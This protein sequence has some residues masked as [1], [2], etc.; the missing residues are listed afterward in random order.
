MR[1]KNVW[2]WLIISALWK[3]DL[4]TDSRCSTDFDR[5]EFDLFEL[6][7]D[8][9]WQITTYLDKLRRTLTNYYYHT[10]TTPLP[11]NYH[12]TT[13]LLPHQYHTNITPLPYHYHTLTTPIP[14]QYY[15]VTTPIINRYHTV[16][17]PLLHHYHI[18]TTPIPHQYYTVTTP[19]PHFEN[20]SQKVDGK[21]YILELGRPYKPGCIFL[22]VLVF[23]LPHAKFGS[24][25]YREDAPNFTI[26]IP[27]CNLHSKHIFVLHGHNVIIT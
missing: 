7:N 20:D 23:I 4:W 14:Y 16:T 1:L 17:T 9:P 3:S 24:N 25:D 5:S 27:T 19:L 6:S 10:I 22:I 21:F 8:I 2:F 11:H 15:T 12:T 18:I 26:S 13:T